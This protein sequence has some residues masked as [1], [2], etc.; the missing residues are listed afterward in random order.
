MEHTVRTYWE[1]FC[2]P[3]FEGLDCETVA[4]LEQVFC[5]QLAALL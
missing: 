2:F 1:S 3:P 5:G 4:E